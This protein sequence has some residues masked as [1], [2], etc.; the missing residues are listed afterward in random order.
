MEVI[1]VQGICCERLRRVLEREGKRMLTK[2]TERQ[3][4]AFEDVDWLIPDSQTSDG[5]P[6][7]AGPGDAARK[8]LVQGDG[9]FYTQV[10]RLPPGFSAPSH[11]HDH[12]EV[13][14]VLSGRCVFDGKPMAER[15]STVVAAN[16]PYSFT[17]GEEGLEFLVVR[18][19]PAVFQEEGR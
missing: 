15:D 5:L 3:I 17:A 1:F 9:G 8:K 7:L 16:Q 4:L 14:M 6:R 18:S 19:A 12:A 11:S 2:D 13:F 10:V